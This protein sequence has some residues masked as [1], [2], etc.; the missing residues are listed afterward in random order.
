[1]VEYAYGYRATRPEGYMEIQN[2]MAYTPSIRGG[3][4]VILIRFKYDPELI[5]DVKKLPGRQWSQSLKCWHVP[6]TPEY[7]KR[8]GLSAAKLP[9]KR[10]LGKVG[11]TNQPALD[12]LRKLLIL[13]GYSKNTQ[14]TYYYE[15]AQLLYFLG[16]SDVNAMDFDRIKSYLL[17]CA[18]EMQMTESQI[19]SRINAVKFYFE[20]VL[21]RGKDIH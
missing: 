2:K 3:K 18:E 1:M 4:P 19:Q 7:R 21:K 16:D 10:K 8:F 5:A 15:F 20:Q 14:R 12:E 17:Y 11:P 9:A 6:D 13:K